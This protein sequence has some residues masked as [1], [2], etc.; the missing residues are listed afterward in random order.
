MQVLD[1][2]GRKASK[3]FEVPRPSLGDDAPVEKV[4]EILDAVRLGGDD[5]LKRLT[6]EFDRV[7]PGSFRVNERE[8]DQALAETPDELR[9][10]LEVAARAIEQFHRQSHATSA[11]YE[12]EGI[13]I[14]RLEIPVARAGI[15]A[16]AG[17]A[18]YPSSVLMSAIPA[19]VAGV[20]SVA[21][22]TPPRRDGSVA[23]EILVACRIAGVD[24]VYRVGG[25]QAIGAMA[26][27]T[28]SIERVDVIAGP[29]SK[30]VALAKRE[31]AG[32]VG[33]SSA[34][35]GPSEV[36][37]VA[38]ESVPPD[39]A[40]LDIIVQAEHGPDGFA[41][42]ITWSED[43]AEKVRESIARLVERSPRRE[44]TLATLDMGGFV[45]LVD[46]PDEAIALT[47]EI[48]PEHLEL[49]VD[50]PES[51]LALVRNAGSVFLGAFAPASVGDY[52]AGPS[53]VIP[54]FGSARF[55]S[56]LGVEDFL[57]RTHAITVS[58]R[59][60]SLAAP[61]VETIAESEQLP[62]HAESVRLRLGRPTWSSQ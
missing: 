31:V 14:D 23:K 25:A 54:T 9:K 34:F 11:R 61:H 21:C 39:W 15:Y 44:D 53:H 8:I 37:V 59:G 18:V 4:R 62:A 50:D 24:E 19:K 42:L 7:D 58:E 20:H 12:S 46:G 30:W 6:I 56:A 35:A 49:M 48:A 10:S 57:R 1:L 13:V 17:L 2:R 27:G 38:D 29:G 47:N 28:E 16:P 60:L 26:F 33:V 52:I 40:A 51:L 32:V 5:A 36:V 43:V 55:A 22:C 3:G 45:A 41:W